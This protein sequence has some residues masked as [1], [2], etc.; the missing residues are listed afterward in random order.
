LLRHVLC[1][2]P[3]RFPDQVEDTRLPGHTLTRA[4]ASAGG[5]WVGNAGVKR[6]GQ[7]FPKP[8]QHQRCAG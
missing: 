1:E 5:V 7:A 3:M 2:E 4:G 6:R 8:N